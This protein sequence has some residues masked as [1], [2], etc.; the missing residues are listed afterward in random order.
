[1]FTGCGAFSAKTMPLRAWV[2]PCSESSLVMSVLTTNPSLKVNE[3]GSEYWPAGFGQKNV[4]NHH[5][6]DCEILSRIHW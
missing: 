2:T 3:K 6:N 4:S 1:M 5:L